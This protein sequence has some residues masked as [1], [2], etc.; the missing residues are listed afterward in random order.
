V[1]S[2]G[3]NA[4]GLYDTHGNVEEWCWDEDADGNRAVRGGS[5]NR[6]ARYLR[7]ADRHSLAPDTRTRYL[8]FRVAL[9]R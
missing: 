2:F 6:T 5:W 8:G 9:S 3:P 7:S 4:L 1:G